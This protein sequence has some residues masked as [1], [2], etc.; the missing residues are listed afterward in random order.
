M[1]LA[2]AL[3]EEIRRVRD[4]VMPVYV[5]IGAPGAFALAMMRQSLDR[6][7]KALSEQDGVA[8]LQ[9]FNDLKGYTT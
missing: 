6:A 2:E 4:D 7:V 5:E 9:C 3:Q 8:C 1:N